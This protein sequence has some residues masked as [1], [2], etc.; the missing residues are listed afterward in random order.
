MKPEDIQKELDKF[1]NGTP[2]EPG[3]KLHRDFVPFQF[4]I[5]VPPVGMWRMGP[6]V[7]NQDIRLDGDKVVVTMATS[8]MQAEPSGNLK[9]EEVIEVHTFP[10]EKVEYVTVKYRNKEN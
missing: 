6:E 8:R 10:C 9:K 1:R 2:V 5:F 3:C 7:A 4:E